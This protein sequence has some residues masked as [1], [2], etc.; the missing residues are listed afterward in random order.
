ML[1]LEIPEE[2][3]PGNLE[4]IFSIDVRN[5]A[6]A[7]G[8]LQISNIPHA[9]ITTPELMPKI[10]DFISEREDGKHFYILKTDEEY[11]ERFAN[12][13]VQNA[14]ENPDILAALENVMKGL[15]RILGIEVADE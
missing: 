7:D 2:K 4:N 5:T 12:W 14:D 3:W 6:I 15:A 9:E 13:V 11:K 1:E 8:E 10:I